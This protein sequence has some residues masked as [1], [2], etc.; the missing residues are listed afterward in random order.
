MRNSGF[1]TVL[2]SLVAIGFCSA[3]A[4]AQSGDSSVLTTL[5]K[6]KKPLPMQSATVSSSTS[7]DKAYAEAMERARQANAA[8]D[9]QREQI[10]F[11]M[12]QKRSAE[13]MAALETEKAKVMAD[14]EKRKQ[15]LAMAAQQQ[16]GAPGGVPTAI[17]AQKAPPPAAAERP[18]TKVF[19]ARK[20]SATDDNTPRR[21]FNVR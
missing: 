14:E 3:A 21:L 4:K 18:K 15:A 16:A 7:G 8:A 1:L 13:I 11:E 9:A 19:T 6:N 20:K 2:L 17:D 10:N 5:L 12:R